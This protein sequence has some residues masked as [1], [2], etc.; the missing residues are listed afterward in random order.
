MYS[1]FDFLMGNDKWA[2]A[3]ELE[4]LSVQQHVDEQ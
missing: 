4:I 3:V 2:P 1:Y